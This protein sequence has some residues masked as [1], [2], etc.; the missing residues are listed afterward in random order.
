[1]ISRQVLS[2]KHSDFTVTINDILVLRLHKVFLD[3][4]PYFS[5]LFD[6][7]PD[8]KEAKFHNIERPDILKDLLYTFYGEPLPAS[9]DAI[10]RLYML[11]YRTML[12]LDP[13][14]DLAN[15]TINDY[16]LLLDVVTPLL[17]HILNYW[18]HCKT[19]YL[20]I[21]IYLS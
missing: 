15:L 12:L 18:L 16:G 11:K 2:G 13:N 8:S 21:T 4:I 5:S 6:D 3:S 1:M 20:I 10:Y 7:I 14:D 17:V 19:I 9:R